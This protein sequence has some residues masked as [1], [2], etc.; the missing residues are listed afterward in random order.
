MQQLINVILALW[1]ILL[2]PLFPHS[3]NV[4]LGNGLLPLL[5]SVG[6]LAGLIIVLHCLL[7]TETHSTAVMHNFTAAQR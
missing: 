6:C 1:L 3:G 7:R 4:R 5:G 2:Q